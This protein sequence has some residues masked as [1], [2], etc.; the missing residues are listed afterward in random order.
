[1]APKKSTLTRPKVVSKAGWVR[2]TVH[3]ITL[4]SGAVVK[5]RFPNL[6]LLIKQDLIPE[7]L[8]QVALLEALSDSDTPVAMQVDGESGKPVVDVETVKSLYELYEFLVVEMLVEPTIEAK[9]L[10]RL[11]QRDLDMLSAVATRKLVMDATGARI[12]VE[13]LD[14]YEVWRDAHACPDDCPKCIKVI[15]RFSSLQPD[16]GEADEE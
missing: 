10:P 16:P 3:T 14:R 7:H 2:L 12:G 6:A 1:M 4:P 5:V 15:E 8:R 13:P 9:D 11:P